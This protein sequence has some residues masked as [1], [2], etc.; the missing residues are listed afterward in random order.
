MYSNVIIYSKQD[1]SIVDASPNVWGWNVKSLVKS[2][3]RYLAQNGCGM[4]IDKCYFVALDNQS[5]RA[6][7]P[8]HLVDGEVKRYSKKRV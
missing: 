3:C 5:H 7:K 8:H 4:M 1:D 6:S 2:A